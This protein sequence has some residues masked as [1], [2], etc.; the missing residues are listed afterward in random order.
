MEL[1]PSRIDHDTRAYLEGLSERR[2]TLARCADC[3]H[4]IH[5][6]RGC[7]PSCWSDRLHH[8]SPTG[9]ASLYSYLIQ[10]LSSGEPPGIIGWAELV[11]QPRLLV[12]APILGVFPDTVRIGAELTLC[13][14][15]QPDGAALAF[16]HEAGR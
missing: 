10:S 6:P 15:E 16:R 5:P 4:W 3:K 13:W 12:V 14:I 1:T 9:R 7:C 2:L 8:E 11:E